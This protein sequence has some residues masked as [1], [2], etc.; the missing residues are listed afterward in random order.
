MSLAWYLVPGFGTGLFVFK[1]RPKMKF[2]ANHAT[3]AR[4]VSNK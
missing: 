1:L 2:T 4:D 3:A